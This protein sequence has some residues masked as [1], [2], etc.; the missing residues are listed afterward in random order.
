VLISIAI[1]SIL[2]GETFSRLALGWVG[3]PSII[4][5]ILYLIAMRQTFRFERSHPTQH[6]EDTPPKYTG[7]PLK[8]VYL[9]FALAAVAVIGAGIWLSLIGHEIAETYSWSTTFVGSLF[10]AI[11]T[12]MPEL[13]VTIAALRL[14]ALD[15]AVADILGAN[16]LDIVI[17][18]WADV[19]YTQGPIL[20]LVSSTHITTT[21]IVIVMSLIAIIGIRFRQKRKTFIITSWYTPALLGLYLF[22]AYR[23]F[24][25]DIGLG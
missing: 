25:S 17:I 1:G 22:G 11:S 16:I 24:S 13:V 8:M 7:I 2:A 6:P 15:M 3:I 18:I 12:S 20:S 21:I 4:I 10:L 14:G 9:R 5:F 19:S 23:L